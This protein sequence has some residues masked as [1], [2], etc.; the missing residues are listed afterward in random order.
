LDAIAVGAGVA[1]GQVGFVVEV[2]ALGAEA[3]A[4]TALE[5]VAV[6]EAAAAMKAAAATTKAAASKAAASKA[7][8]ATR[9]P[10]EQTRLI[11]RCACRRL[12][13]GRDGR[14]KHGDEGREVGFHD[15]GS[16]RS[17]SRQR[18]VATVGRNDGA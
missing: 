7:A 8:A 13:D 6:A 15:G 14:S 18:L 10:M 11:V 9:L 4:A 1:T 17:W 5:A 12:D 3:A 2:T 16:Q